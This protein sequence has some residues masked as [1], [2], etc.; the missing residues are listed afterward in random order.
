MTHKRKRRNELKANKKKKKEHLRERNNSFRNH[1]LH[2][3]CNYRFRCMR[4]DHLF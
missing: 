3:K 2:I 4:F 1:R